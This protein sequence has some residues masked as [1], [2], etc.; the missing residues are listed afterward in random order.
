LPIAAESTVSH[1]LRCGLVL[2]FIF[3]AG[4]AAWLGDPSDYLRVDPALARLLRGMALIKGMIAIGAAGAVYWR[5]AW[6]VRAA[7]AVQY[8]IAAWAL[9]AASVLIWQLSFIVGAALLFHAGALSLLWT[10][11]REM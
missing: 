7:V 10:A 9:A 3:A 5:L 6:P 11:W 2:G 1:L 8:L 4:V